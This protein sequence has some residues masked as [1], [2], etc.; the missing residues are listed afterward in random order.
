MSLHQ[1][2]KVILPNVMQIQIRQK[3]ELNQEAN[4]TIEDMCIDVWKY[5]KYNEVNYE[6]NEQ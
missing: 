3:T 4:L 2:L 5:V 6:R 1:D